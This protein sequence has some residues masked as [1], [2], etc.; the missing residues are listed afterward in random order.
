MKCQCCDGDKVD[1]GL[2]VNPYASELWDDDTLVPLCDD[3]TYELA[4]DI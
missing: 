2:R 3:C 4:Q 1:T